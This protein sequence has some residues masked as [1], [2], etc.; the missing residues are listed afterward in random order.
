MTDKSLRTNVLHGTLI[1]VIVGVVA[2]FASFI[3][4]TILAA[5][6][7]TTYQSDA[8]YMVWGVHS[9]VYPMMSVG[10][11]NI[12]LPLYKEHISKGEIKEANEL[13]NKSLSFFNSISF[14]FVFLLIIFAPLCVSLIAPGFE[15]ATR[16]LCIKL[17]RISA[18]MYVFII[19]SAVYASI[20]QCH[21]KYFG[22][23]I[24]EVVSHLPIILAALLFYPYFGVESLAIALVISGVLRLLIEIPYIDWEYTFKIDYKFDSP[25]FIKMLKRLPSALISAGV[26]QLN[27]LIDKSMASTLIEG[28][29]SGLNYGHKLMNVFGGL[30]SSAVATA[31]YPQM[32]ELIALKKT[33]ALSQLVTKIICIY[34]F[35][36]LPV[37]LGCILFRKEIVS[38]VFQRGNFNEASV[39]LTSNIFGLYAVGIFFVACS[40]VINNLFYSYGNTKI[41]MYISLAN[42]LVNVSLNFLLIN[43]YGI[44]G[45]AFA[46]S[47][48]AIIAFILRIKASNKYL[49]LNNAHI[50]STVFKVILSSLLACYIPRIIFWL[51]PFNKLVILVVSAVVAFLL[52]FLF[53]K[54]LMI[55]EINDIMLL[56]K[57]ILKR[58][59]TAS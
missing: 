25:D 44:D 15:G 1:I 2:K 45:L 37:T 58:N 4:E 32:I 8:Y 48:S 12:F 30:L 16:E 13:A 24:R 6:L 28:A 42:L 41:P 56:I 38:V 26:V 27:S 11:W 5:Y 21:N 18:P 29:V 59:K 51:Y 31:L 43:L 7:G 47:L 52:F 40:S 50:F 46:T 55:D 35:I 39:T 9:A 3:S 20:L 36:M 57:K 10:I 23:Q 33:K 49:Q 54:L 14:I 22:S 19:S 53:S 34:S 17:V